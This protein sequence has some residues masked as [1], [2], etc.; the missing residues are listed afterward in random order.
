MLIK[1]P[2]YIWLIAYI[3]L[4]LFY[5]FLILNNN[6][7]YGEVKDVIIS[8][9]TNI[10]L[11]LLLLLIS[12]LY[13]NFFLVDFSHRIPSFPIKFIPSNN[14][15]N[16]I[17]ILV[18]TI[19]ILFFIYIILSGT[20]VAGSA[21]RDE[22]ILSKVWVLVPID[23]IFLLYYSTYR[24]CRYYYLN[25]LVYICSNLLRGWSGMFLTII[26][27]ESCRRFRLN[28]I[29]LKGVLIF[30]LFIILIYPVIY[31]FKLYLRYKSIDSSML[32]SFVLD[33]NTSD[34]LSIFYISISQ[35][36]DRLQLLSSAIS[37]YEMSESLNHAIAIGKIHPF[38]LEGIHGVAID[39]LFF[40]T[41]NR[42][43]I[44]EE[45]STL[46]DP[47]S[48]QVNWNSNPTFVGWF[49]VEPFFAIINILY[50]SFLVVVATVF[51]KS[52]I[53]SE[54]SKDMLWYMVLVLM[55]PGWYGA[56]FLFVY[57]CILFFAMHLLISNKFKIPFK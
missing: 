14:Q 7:L 56:Y 55:V 54:A 31:Y 18:L 17:S 51:M 28:Q 1:K 15:V 35:I 2:R 21:L 46:L 33:L 41:N 6:V 39:R 27:I 50:A 20:R 32:D 30:S 11:I 49:F 38:W 16:I 57:S 34:I 9:R 40:N 48:T 3:I 43:S 37:T 53:I 47:F 26:F 5:Y 22:S 8:D 23:V 42:L 29:S 25:L 4:N 36:G 24:S 10:F 19:Q 12:Y 13:F 52:I 45:I 44:G